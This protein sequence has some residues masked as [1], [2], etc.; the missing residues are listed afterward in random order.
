M[1]T[2]VR[3]DQIARECGVSAAT[4]SRVMNRPELVAP[5]TVDK[6][7]KAMDALDY[8]PNPHA[9]SLKAQSL[10]TVGLIF[11]NDL[12]ELAR[13]PF[14]G[15]ASTAVYS[16]L[17]DRGMNPQIVATAHP[18]SSMRRFPYQSSLVRF[19][20]NGNAKGYITIGSASPDFWSALVASKVP[21][22]SWGPP[23][24]EKGE[25]P[26]VEVDN[27][28]GGA[29][30]TKHLYERGYRQIAHI[31]AS[32]HSVTSDER[33]AGLSEAKIELGLEARADLVRTGDG[34]FDSGWEQARVLLSLDDPPDAIFCHNDETAFGA[35]RYAES[36]G[37]TVPKDLGIVG[38]DNIAAEMHMLGRAITSVAQPYE[39]I[40][41]YLAEGISA[42]INGQTVLSSRIPSSLFVGDSS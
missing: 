14:W 27:I 40:G 18:G 31:A 8:R 1:K 34:S 29:L 36:I 41:T 15:L 13:N 21:A 26:S 9:R 17:L 30:A 10:Q 20:R 3:I 35:L 38:F 23:S 33:L 6:I 39:E 16:A 11:L 37:R 24:P 7:Q 28:G 19:L 2:P 5:A 42:L 22:I 25:I 4:V 12:A 32:A